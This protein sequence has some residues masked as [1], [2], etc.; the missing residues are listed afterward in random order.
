MST[1]NDPAKTESCHALVPITPS[2]WMPRH[3]FISAMEAH[4]TALEIAVRTV[5][6]NADVATKNIEK[7]TDKAASSIDK[8]LEAMNEFRQAL[9][10][11]GASMITRNEY[12]VQHKALDDKIENNYKTIMSRIDTNT[13]LLNSMAGRREE[14]KWFWPLAISGTLLFISIASLI[15]THYNPK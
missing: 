15:L 1:E 7:A 13:V 4:R 2:Y 5:E 11:Q 3:E 8:R 14:Q 9:A 12:I 10:D 6:H